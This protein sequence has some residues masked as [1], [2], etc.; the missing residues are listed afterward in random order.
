MFPL[1]V[2]AMLTLAGE[3]RADLDRDGVPDHLESELASRFVPVFR[4]SGS[5][6]DALPAEFRADHP[7]PAVAERRGAISIQVFPWAAALGEAVSL[8]IHYYHL[9]ARDCGRAGHPLDAEHVSVVVSA[10]ALDSPVDKWK[11]VYWYGAAHEDTACDVSNAARAE[12]LDSVTKGA[13]V[14]VSRGKHASFLAAERCGGGCGGDTCEGATAMPIAKLINL[15]E[16]DFPMDC[17]RWL[18]SARWP[19]REKMRSDFTPYLLAK[20]TARDA[21]GIVAVPRNHAQQALFRAGGSTGAALGRS[22]TTTGGALAKAGSRTDSAVAE[23]LGKATDATGNATRH[24]LER[25]ADALGVALQSSG[26]A[27]RKSL[28]ATGRFIGLSRR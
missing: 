9:W 7:H 28:N 10:P 8:E 22:G 14:W 5:E 20:L 17:C 4:V 2:V 18:Q 6:C 24:G 27:V 15:G 1:A 23:N 19:L 25:T 16:P 21:T 26:Q 13:N 11:A 3:L 12:D